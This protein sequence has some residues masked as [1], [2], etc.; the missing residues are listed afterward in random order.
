MPPPA[1]ERMAWNTRACRYSFL[2]YSFSFCVFVYCALFCALSIVV[3]RYKTTKTKTML[4]NS[5]TKRGGRG[6]RGGVDSREFPLRKLLTTSKRS[7]NVHALA[8]FILSFIV[9][10]LFCFYFF[11]LFYAARASGFWLK[12]QRCLQKWA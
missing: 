2:F 8:C 6:V 11:F 9:T 3:N 1:A 10:V 4:I 12:L 5:I 7:E